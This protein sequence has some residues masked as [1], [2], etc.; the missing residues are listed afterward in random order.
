[1]VCGGGKGRAWID[2]QNDVTVKDVKLAQKENFSSVEHL[3]RYTTLGMATDQGKT[4][5]VLGLAIMAGLTG[6]TIPETGRRSTARPI[7]RLRWARWRAGRGG[8]S[9]SRSA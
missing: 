2:P 1:M 7:R 6:R 3:K 4:G 8:K 9:S 5:N